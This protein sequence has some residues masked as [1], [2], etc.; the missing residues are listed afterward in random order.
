MTC[1]YSATEQRQLQVGIYGATGNTGAELVRLLHE[2]PLAEVAFGT[3]RSCAGGLLDT[4][5]PAAPQLALIHPEEADPATIDVAFLCLPHGASAPVAEALL[6]AGPVIVDLSGDLRLRDATEH[7]TIYGS[8]RSAALMEQVV[9]GLPEVNRGQLQSARVVSN[10]GCYATAVALALLPLAQSD[11]LS[12]TVIVN[13]ISGVSG[14]G[15]APSAT[16]HFC[17]AHDDVMPYKVGRQHRHLPEIEQTL[18]GGGGQGQASFVFT[19]HLGPMSRGILATCYVDGAGLSESEARSLYAE[20]YVQHP[21]TRVLP[22]GRHA[23]IRA[24]AHS[25]RAVLSVHGVGS[26]NGLIVA[27]AIDN[28]VKGAA[29]QAI[30]NMNLACGLPEATGLPGGI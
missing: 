2:H 13:A 4:I 25:N 6:D 5:D 17:S 11:R 16:T 8:P 23:R 14:A 29:G 21:F 28:L 22:E 9:Y 19:P 12:G 27:S 7:S 1:N 15:R 26:T 30:Q 24:V 3:S 10:P 20:Y 18:G